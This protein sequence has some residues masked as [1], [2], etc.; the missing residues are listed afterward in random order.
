MK[1]TANIFLGL[2]LVL[3]S[4]SACSTQEEEPAA[5]EVS[6]LTSDE[7]QESL[8]SKGWEVQTTSAASFH[9]WEQLNPTV[10]ILAQNYSDEIVIV[11]EFADEENAKLAFSSV[12]PVS[13][14]SVAVT[15]TST[16]Q[17]A[18]VPLSDESGYWLFRQVGD[19]VFGGC[20][21]SESNASEFKTLFASFSTGTEADEDADASAQETSVRTGVDSTDTSSIDENVESVETSTDEQTGSDS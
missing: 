3:G 19:D 18:L 8:T 13:D 12:V 4:M 15:T 2:L 5:P 10:L 9:L 7:I 6:V 20:F 11:G 14:D 21:A 16:F 17:Q 1:K